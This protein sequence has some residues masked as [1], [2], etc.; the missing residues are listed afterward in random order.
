MEPVSSIEEEP[1]KSLSSL[2]DANRIEMRWSD[3]LSKQLEI[4]LS[5]IK[6]AAK[7]HNSAAKKCKS[8]YRMLSIPAAIIP[9]IV[10]V[11]SSYIPD[12]IIIPI[13]LVI[14]AILTTINGSMNYGSLMSRHYT[15]EFRYSNL[16]RK[17]EY[18]LAQPKTARQDPDVLLTELR[19]DI[20]NISEVSPDI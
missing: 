14:S 12:G 3:R 7:S 20:D 10:G 5:E 11:L 4:W 15:T 9:L 18:T 19:G 8:R 6:T 17:I 16:V 2:D 1:L 13:L